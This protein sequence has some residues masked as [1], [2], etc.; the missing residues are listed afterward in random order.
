MRDLTIIVPIAIAAG[1]LLL[2]SR[3]I[4]E[5]QDITPIVQ[6]KQEF[7]AAAIW[8]GVLAPFR[9]AGNTINAELTTVDNYEFAS[10]Y[11]PRGIRNNNPGNIRHGDSWRGMAANQ[12]DPA[13]VTFVAPEYG[14][15]AMGKVLVNYERLHGLNTVAG[16]IDRWAP[17]TENN[18][19]AY[20]LNVAERLG[21]GINDP[22]DVK[23][24]LPQLVPAIIQHENGLQ[25]YMPATINA[26]LALV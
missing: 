9:D 13:F 4:G 17:P 3:Q 15:R 20:Q 2:L 22:I 5:G 26:G 18:T 7:D 6:T 14:I 21:V 24:K 12:P 1:G 19:H 25:P 16:I 11:Y 8:D 23:A 10:R